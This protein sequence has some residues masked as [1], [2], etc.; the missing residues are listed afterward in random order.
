MQGSHHRRT[1]LEEE[2]REGEKVF[3]ILEK[4]LIFKLHC[5]L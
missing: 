3:Y 2:E 1:I 4:F 5:K